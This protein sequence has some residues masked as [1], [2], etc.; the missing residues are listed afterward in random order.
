ME[1]EL[2]GVQQALAAFGEAWLKVEEEASR[3]IDERVLLLVEL[4]ANKDELSPFQAEASK[5]K[6]A[7]EEAFDSGFDAIFNYGY[8]CVPLHTIFLGVSH[9]SQ[10]GCLTCQS[11]YLPSFLSILDAPRVLPPEFLPLI[12]RQILERNF[13]PRVFQPTRRG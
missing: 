1:S 2:E 12:L 3:L 10:L 5:E 13:Y 8:G 6:K 9:G 7:L 11:C 4:Q